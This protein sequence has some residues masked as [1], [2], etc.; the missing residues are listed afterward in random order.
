MLVGLGALRSSTDIRDPAREI[1]LGSTAV[2]TTGQR[3][4]PRARLGFAVRDDLV[5]NVGVDLGHE[6]LTRSTASRDGFA[7]KTADTDARRLSAHGSGQIVWDPLS[8]LR[9][10]LLGALDA[11]DTAERGAASATQTPVST[12]VGARLGD[13]AFALLANLGRAVRLPTL[14]ELFGQSAVLGGNPALLPERAW[15]LD[16]GVRG[17]RPLGRPDVSFEAQ[18]FGFGRLTDD[19][20]VYQRDSFLVFRPHNVRSSRTLGGEGTLALAA[21]RIV[22][23]EQTLTFLDA[24]DT[25]GGPNVFTGQLPFLPRLV[26]SSRLTIIPWAPNDHQE[27]SV[28]GTVVR[29]GARFADRS[30]LVVVPAQTTL[31]LETKLRLPFGAHLEATLRGRADNVTSTRRVDVIGYPL[32]PRQLFVS[33]ELAATP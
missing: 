19:L 33:L 23:A 12:R 24:R 25:S 27:A 28:S 15:G 7:G 8:R 9:L 20:V 10:S 2:H 29:Q 1:G 5:A 13:D 17:K 18:A 26:S 32:S 16:A 22:R 11:T 14:G 3:F 30:G 6:S 21:L 31:D 4:T